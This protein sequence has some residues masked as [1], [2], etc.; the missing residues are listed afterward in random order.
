MVGDVVGACAALSRG[1]AVAIGC[2]CCAR[3]W[4]GA[5]CVFLGC[6]R[7]VV[8]VCARGVFG[9]AGALI[10][11]GARFCADLAVVRVLV[12]PS[13]L[14][15][16]SLVVVLFSGVLSVVAVLSSAA[17]VVSAVFFLVI[18]CDLPVLWSGSL[19]FCC[20]RGKWAQG[21]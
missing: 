9:P 17:L 13:V 10:R 2:S 21:R 5:A 19:W 15:G 11:G 4:L 1:R 16:L 7:A 8:V 6:R 20:R 14:V 18:S 3:S 12:L